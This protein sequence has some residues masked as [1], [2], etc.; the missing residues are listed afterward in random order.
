MANEGIYGI[1]IEYDG[2]DI[3]PSLQLQ[4]TEVIVLE[5]MVRR[6]KADYTSLFYDLEY[7]YNISDVVG[8]KSTGVSASRIEAE[9]LKDERVQNAKCSIIISPDLTGELSVYTI[10]IEIKLKDS[11]STYNLTF[12]LQ[13]EDVDVVLNKLI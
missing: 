3:F 9:C 10:T 13:D 5:S 1:D 4:N 8:L 2:D 7:G 6:L 11:G 12:R